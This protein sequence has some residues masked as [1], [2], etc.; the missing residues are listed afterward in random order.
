MTRFLPFLIIIV[1]ILAVAAAAKVLLPGL[2]AKKGSGKGRGVLHYVKQDT[3]FTPAE[4]SFL[5]V[6]EAAPY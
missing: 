3:L 2:V 4:R 1:V 5:G 6:L